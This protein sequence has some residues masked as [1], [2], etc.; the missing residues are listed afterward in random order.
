MVCLS[1]KY[2]KAKNVSVFQDTKVTRMMPL[3][4]QRSLC[5]SEA[6]EGEA[7]EKEVKQQ[8]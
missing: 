2:D 5:A 3:N 7:V 6:V 4:D 1:E 8:V